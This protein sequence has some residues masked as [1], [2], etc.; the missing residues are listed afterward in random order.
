MEIFEPMVNRP[1]IH[2]MRSPAIWLL[3]ISAAL[4]TPRLCGQAIR[5]D[6]VPLGGPSSRRI[7]RCMVQD[8][9]GFLWFG[10]THGLLRYDGETIISYNFD[11]KDTNS[12]S[13]DDVISLADDLLGTLW[14]GTERGGLNTIDERS[15]KISRIRSA[16]PDRQARESI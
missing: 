13:G 10:T 3:A 16:L 4:W 12:L 15:G 9:R 8:A 11:A 7:V 1:P 14:V 5:P 6:H 2:R